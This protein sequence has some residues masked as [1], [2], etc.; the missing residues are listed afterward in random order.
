M[1]MKRLPKVRELSRPTSDI[2]MLGTVGALLRAHYNSLLEQP[3]PEHLG[4][5]I[6]QLE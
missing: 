6:R 4:N 3:A 5:L 2:V 1:T